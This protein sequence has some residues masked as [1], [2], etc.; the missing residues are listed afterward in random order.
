MLIACPGCSHLIDEQVTDC[1]RCGRG[2]TAEDRHRAHAALQSS[3]AARRFWARCGIGFLV[4]ALAWGAVSALSLLARRSDSG[5]QRVAAGKA[6]SPEPPSPKADDVRLE[7]VEL[8]AT[9]TGVSIKVA[10]DNVGDAGARVALWPYVVLPG[11][12][13]ISR[14]LLEGPVFLDVEP[15]KRSFVLAPVQLEGEQLPDVR[16]W[17]RGTDAGDYG[18]EDPSV[19]PLGGPPLTPQLPGRTKRTGIS[20]GHGREA[21]EV[22]AF[23]ITPGRGLGPIRFGMIAEEAIAAGSRA[24][25]EDAEVSDPPLVTV[26][27]PRTKVMAYAVA[28]PGGAPRVYEVRTW[29]P[30]FRLKQHVSVGSSYTTAR[31]SLGKPNY[32]DKVPGTGARAGWRSGMWL[33]H[34][35]AGKIILIGVDSKETK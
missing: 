27:W 23:V 17:V 30:H 2:V 35:V 19:E 10:A 32:Y 7:I 33:D 22:D 18:V 9:D 1:P 6:Q 29:N 24:W 31:K 8:L 25:G 4:V 15:G 26:S 20:K 14:S 13:K 11:G 34:D 16:G 28:K 5:R 12:K 21:K 3:A